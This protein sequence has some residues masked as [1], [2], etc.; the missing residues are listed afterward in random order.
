ME[1]RKGSACACPEEAG[2]DAPGVGERRLNS[3]GLCPGPGFGSRGRNEEGG[4]DGDGND[5]SVL[6]GVGGQFS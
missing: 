5:G 4:P 6:V 1:A 3:W 2:N